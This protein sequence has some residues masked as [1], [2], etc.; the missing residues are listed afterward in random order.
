MIIERIY[1]RRV[2]ASADFLS[3]ASRY[4]RLHRAGHQWSGLCPFHY[5]RH[6]SL[7]VEPQRKIFHC[8][9]CG[10]GGDIFAFVMRA[11]NCCFRSALE[12]VAGYSE[13]VA[14]GSELRSSSRFDSGV[15]AT[16]LRPPKAGVSYSQASDKART[17]ILAALDATNHR[18]RAIGTANGE[19]RDELSTA[20][21]PE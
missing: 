17:E 2:K 12:I 21:E 3:V 15:G 5:E 6:A 18:L 10:A 14:R 13:G 8:F 20:C 16:P 19:T 4:T 1:V 7:F 9:G 11:E